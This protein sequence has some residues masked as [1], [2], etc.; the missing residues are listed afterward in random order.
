V[1]PHLKKIIHALFGNSKISEKLLFIDF[2]VLALSFHVRKMLP[3]ILKLGFSSVYVTL[4]PDLVPPLIV[5]GTIFS[6][7]LTST[8]L[9]V[10]LF[11]ATV[12]QKLT[13]MFLLTI[14]GNLG[15]LG[16][17]TV[18]N[19]I[20]CQS[21]FMQQPSVT[22]NGQKL[23]YLNHHQ[24]TPGTIM[25]KGH[26]DTPVYQYKFNEKATFEL[27]VKK[28][29]TKMDQCEML[30]EFSLTKCSK[31][32]NDSKA[33]VPYPKKLIKNNRQTNVKNRLKLMMNRKKP[34][35]PRLIPLDKRTATLKTLNDVNNS[36]TTA[37]LEAIQPTVDRFSKKVKKYENRLKNEKN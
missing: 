5:G 36:D 28:K 26:I 2:P 20:D 10:F 13:Y 18:L 1:D 3:T 27:P 16:T 34:S 29:F 8:V 21:I 9:P 19:K 37:N 23:R 14:G 7:M 32:P 15:Y 31:T 30:F 25:I 4:P 12:V 33:L 17:S 6:V 24:L 35:S 22:I 11:P